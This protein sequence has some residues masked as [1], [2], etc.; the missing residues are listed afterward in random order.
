MASH[1]EPSKFYHERWG[2]QIGIRSGPVGIEFKSFSEADK[3]QNNNNNQS[4]KK[5]KKKWFALHYMIF[6]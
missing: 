1:G 5:S 2:M 3:S 6:M 4:N